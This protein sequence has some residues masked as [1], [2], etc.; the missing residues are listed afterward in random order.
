[1]LKKKKPKLYIEAKRLDGE[2]FDQ[3]FSG[4]YV[5]PSIHLVEPSRASVYQKSEIFGPNVAISVIDNMDEALS[6]NNSTG[7]GLVTSI[8]TQDEVLYKK[9]CKK[10]KVGL[11]NWNRSTIGANSKLPFGGVGRSGNDRPSGHFA[12]YYC[13]TPL[14]SLQD[15]N[16]F[17]KDKAL[18]GINY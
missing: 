16:E 9:A 6:I 17:H 3:R 13:S 11:L 12:I 14:A 2:H 15:Q 1:M 7:Y 5:S 8:F 4:Y 10:A 18:P